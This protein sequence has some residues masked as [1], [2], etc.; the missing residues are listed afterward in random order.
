M[1]VSAQIHAPEVVQTLRRADE[2]LTPARDQP[3]ACPTGSSLTTPTT[4][5]RPQKMTLRQR[6]FLN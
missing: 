3:P 1:E 2:S 4:L 5:S 6:I